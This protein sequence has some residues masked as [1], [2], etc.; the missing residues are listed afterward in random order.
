MQ[1]VHCNGVRLAEPAGALAG[2]GW[3]GLRA[4]ALVLLVGVIGGCLGGP[5]P[6]PAG[7]RD[8]PRPDG[9]AERAGRPYAFVFIRTGTLAEPTPAQQREAMDGHFAN[10]Q[11]LAERGLL[12][13]AG[14]LTEPRSDPDH[15]G[16]FVFDARTAAEGLALANTDPARAMGVFTMDPWVL[17]TQAPLTDLPALEEQQRERRRREGQGDDAWQGRS[18]VLAST[19]YDPALDASILRLWQDG[20]G[21]LLAGRLTNGAGG[22]LLLVWLDATD[23]DRGRAMLPE[24]PWTMHGWYG[25]E[26]IA[27]LPPP[28]SD[29]P[30]SR[31][32]P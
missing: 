28:G 7:D 26:T 15:R 25:S 30:Q 32:E 22:D 24:G 16:L 21:V 13:M 12:L 20:A 9:Q 27:L 18:Y 8:H 5:C 19:P 17:T 29:R 1:L 4:W 3:V 6:E 2:L 10:M 23:P 14:P 31:P 11:R